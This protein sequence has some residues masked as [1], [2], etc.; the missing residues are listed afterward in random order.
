MGE[1]RGAFKSH[2]EIEDEDFFEMQSAAF[3]DYTQEAAL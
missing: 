2:Y 1:T 3:G